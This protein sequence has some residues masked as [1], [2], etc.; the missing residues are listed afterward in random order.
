MERIVTDPA[1]LKVPQ[2]LIALTD[3]LGNITDI[4]A[5]LEALSNQLPSK[6][7]QG[8]VTQSLSVVSPFGGLVI[9]AGEAHVGAVGGQKLAVQ[10]T[11]TRPAD[12]T[13][14]AANDVVGDATVWTF[15][16]LA[17]ISAGSGYVV[18]ARLITDNNAVT[19]RFRLHLFASSVVAI[20]DNSPYTALWAQRADRL[21][22]I[23]FAAMN[24]EGT[25]STSASSLN[26]TV[27][28][29]YV[30]GANLRTIYGILETLDAFT[31][32]SA[33]NFFIELTSEND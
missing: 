21:G 4:A 25:G 27:R 19:A 31:P 15:A 30:C 24:T 6:L 12:T 28:L 32:T 33:Q 5:R 16:T 2:Q 18:K 29:P 23:D 8:D 20:A 14:Y 11:K 3:A 9:G 1:G 26:A 7:G 13:A 22:Y 10:V 17:R